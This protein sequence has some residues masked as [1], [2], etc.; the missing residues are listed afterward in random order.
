MINYISPKSGEEIANELGTTRQYVSNTIKSGLKKLYKGVK[1]KNPDLTPFEVVNSIMVF[2]DIK[3]TIEI[4]K[5]F[6]AFPPTIKNE[7]K[8]SVMR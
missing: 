3:D 1:A 4:E 5:F 8:L 6:N 2:F 7:I